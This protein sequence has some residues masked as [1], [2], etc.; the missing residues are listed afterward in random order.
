LLGALRGVETRT[1]LCLNLND[2]RKKYARKME[3]LEGVWDGSAGEVQAGY[4]LYSV[5]GAEPA[6]IPLSFK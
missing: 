6:G 2:V 4:W 5:I 1:V 3:F